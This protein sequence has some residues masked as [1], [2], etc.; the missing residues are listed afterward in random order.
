MIIIFKRPI[1]NTKHRK[2]YFRFGGTNTAHFIG[3]SFSNLDGGGG[4]A[5]KT[6]EDLG[7]VKDR[8]KIAD[9]SGWPTSNGTRKSG[10]RSRHPPA[11]LSELAKNTECRPI[12]NPLGRQ[13]P[14]STCRRARL[15]PGK[16]GR[17]TSTGGPRFRPRVPPP[18]HEGAAIEST[19]I[20][21]RTQQLPR[22]SPTDGS[23]AAAARTAF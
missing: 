5:K 12:G 7:T 10:S 4:R 23:S 8:L 18:G 21:V 3:R 6:I 16:N 13:K 15:P 17:Q 20:A 19:G 9:E 1:Y 11:A 2:L 22:R 14:S